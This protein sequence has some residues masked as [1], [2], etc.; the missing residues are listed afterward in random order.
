MYS[1]SKNENTIDSISYMVGENVPKFYVR[2]LNY[3]NKNQIELDSAGYDDEDLDPD[4]DV[5]VAY[6]KQYK[7]YKI[8]L[9]NPPQQPGSYDFT[10]SFSA[11]NGA[12]ND[13]AFTVKV[14]KKGT[15]GETI[16]GAK[17]IITKDVE[18]GAGESV[19]LKVEAS[20]AEGKIIYQWYRDNVK[21]DG[22]TESS[23]TATE[24]GAYYVK[25]TANK[26]TVVSSTANVVISSSDVTIP[27]ITISAVE[28][29]KIE[30]RTLKVPEAS[31]GVLVIEVENGVPT[32]Y[33]W[34][35]VEETSGSDT[36]VT[37]ATNQTYT[38]LK[39]AGYYCKV[40]VGEYTYQSSTV[41]VIEKDIVMSLNTN[42]AEDAYTNEELTVEAKTDVP[43]TFAYQWYKDDETSGTPEKMDGATEKTYSPTKEG[44]YYCRVTATSVAT[45]ATKP[46]D[47][48]KVSVRGKT[49]NDP[50][51]PTI[52]SIDGTKDLREGGTLKLSV[53]ASTSDGG[54]LSYQ[55]YKGTNPISGA[56]KNTYEKS[57]AK[58]EDS[59]D[60]KCRVINTLNG[61]TADAV[62]STVTVLVRHNSTVV[63]GEDFGNGNGSFDFN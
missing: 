15:D 54:S 52:E 47:T 34:Y 49:A 25:V 9:N 22:A 35:M 50:V 4:E 57:G 63:G 31:D 45:G 53:T 28:P 56:T 24:T 12:E 18:D 23:Y 29:Y 58:P 41:N 13:L 17:P 26:Q 59:G 36:V 21:I 37:G 20:V 44:H 62:S 40:V 1:D 2:S 27:T 43:C 7:N 32:S 5:T 10:L 33:Q 46:L 16:E 51:K 48:N 30:D 3:P 60:Y 14:T 55:W 8:T 38:P 6:R 19:E 61:K 39:F 42:F 11:D